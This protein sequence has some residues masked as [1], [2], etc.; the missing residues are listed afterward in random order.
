MCKKMGIGVRQ[1]L[2]LALKQSMH[3]FDNMNI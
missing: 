2:L 1:Q 3:K